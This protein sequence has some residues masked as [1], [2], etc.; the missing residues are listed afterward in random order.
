MPGQP[1]LEPGRN[2]QQVPGTSIAETYEIPMETCVCVA[3]PQT[4][5]RGSGRVSS[6]SLCVWGR[7]S[8]RKLSDG[9]RGGSGAGRRRRFKRA[10]KQPARTFPPSFTRLSACRFPRPHLPRPRTARGQASARLP[11]K[12]AAAGRDGPSSR[13]RWVWCL[14]ACRLAADIRRERFWGVCL[15]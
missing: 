9:G 1:C 13:R 2:E 5:Q 7:R 14:P 11:K 10:W 12:R 6:S 8:L 3:Q 15:R 4:A